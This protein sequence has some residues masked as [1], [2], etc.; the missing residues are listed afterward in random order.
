VAAENEGYTIPNFNKQKE[1]TLKA[2]ES[3]LVNVADG[4][5]KLH[6]PSTREALERAIEQCAATIAAGD[7]V[8][9]FGTGHGSFAALEM[10]PR[11]GTCSGFRP[12][13]ENPLSNFHNIFGTQGVNQ[14][15]FLHTTEGYAQSIMS[16]Y[17]FRSGETI[18][19]FSQSGINAVVID[20]AIEARKM[21]MIV[22]AVTS[23]PH[24]SNVPPK[25]SSGKRLFECADIIVDTGV[26]LSDAA[27]MIEGYPHPVGPTST[28]IATAITHAIVS[29]TVEALVRRGVEPLVMVNPNTAGADAANAQN[30]RVLEDSWNRFYNRQSV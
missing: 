14:Y 18:V 15:R 17:R 4:L 20:F 13:I 26:P 29:G 23:L 28:I 7:L 2:V 12:I 11:T 3:Y 27:V 25:H 9:T 19:L 5:N 10:F 1:N 30:E 6:Q 22:I 21:G 8:Y 24:S 16:S